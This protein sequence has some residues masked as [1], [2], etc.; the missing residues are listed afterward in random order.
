MN[1]K[2]AK[3]TLAVAL[4]GAL[5]FASPLTAL[6]TDLSSEG[7][8]T[9]E[10][11]KIEN[12]VM[13]VTLPTIT[14]TPYD[15]TADP[16]NL[17]SAKNNRLDGKTVDNSTGILFEYEQDKFGPNSAVL[18]AESKSAVDV[19][20]TV[21]AK[22]K[23][24]YDGVVEFAEDDSFKDKEGKDIT[25]KTIYLAVVDSTD[26]DADKHV[27]DAIKGT[28]EVKAA[29]VTSTV[30]GVPTNF[31]LVNDSGTYKYAQV[32]SPTDYNKAKF[33]LTGAINPN[34]EWTGVAEKGLPSIEVTW[35]YAKH[36]DGPSV[37][38]GTAS[39][40]TGVDFDVTFTK[41]TASTYTFSGLAAGETLSSVQQSADLNGT[42]NTS[43]NVTLDGSSVKV[44]SGMW[45]SASAGDTRYL[46]VT[47]SA[48]TYVLKVA[49]Q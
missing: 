1:N 44:A 47:S 43:G 7:T 37:S 13:E 39:S 32:D 14:G 42:Y 26:S 5:A 17:L 3:R 28:E 6:A 8:A 36:Q 30:S 9:Y 34:A 35:S 23:G 33:N 45:G 12:D 48:K 4:A 41:G 40:A 29:K 16:N 38:G 49:I 21:T 15:F 10:G 2:A 11:D 25:D 46:K 18:E 19:D 20:V 27:K 31:E 24:T 22:V